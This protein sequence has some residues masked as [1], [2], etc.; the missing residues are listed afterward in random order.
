MVASGQLKLLRTQNQILYLVPKKKVLCSLS[1]CGLSRMGK[2]I[3]TSCETRFLLQKLNE[4][5]VDFFFSFLKELQS[6]C[7]CVV[8]AQREAQGLGSALDHLFMHF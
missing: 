7:S 5:H 8:W 4:R 6:F 2:N 3:I 1:D